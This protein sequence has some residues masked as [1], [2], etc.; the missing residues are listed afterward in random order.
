MEWLRYSDNL[1]IN[2]DLVSSVEIYQHKSSDVASIV[3]NF[4]DG[5]DRTINEGS[6]EEMEKETARIFEGLAASD[7][8]VVDVRDRL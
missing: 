7:S 1:A 3:V 5:T 4:S 2:L 8:G 6:R